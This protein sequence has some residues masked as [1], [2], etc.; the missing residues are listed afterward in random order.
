MLQMISNAIDALKE[1]GGSNE[2][3]IG[4]YIKSQYHELPWNHE[5][6]LSHH[7]GKLSIKGE[8][9][10]TSNGCY[11]LRKS[12]LNPNKRKQHGEGQQ[13]GK[14][15]NGNDDHNALQI[16]PL[17]AFIEEKKAISMSLLQFKPNKRRGRPPK[18]KE[19]KNMDNQPKRRGRTKKASQ[20]GGGDR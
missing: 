14:V 9:F 11:T 15:L 8:I 3:S 18:L 10:T 5:K 16:K 2:V 4:A 13:E 17:S 20:S 19:E 6:F 1:E 7:L 12:N